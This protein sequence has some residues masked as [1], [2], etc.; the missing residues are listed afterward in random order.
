MLRVK[1]VARTEIG[2]KMY[3][4]FGRREGSPAA[5]MVIYQLPGANALDV[6]E[7]IQDADEGVVARPSRRGSS[8]RSSTTTRCS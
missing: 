7:K 4:S 1:D 5:V 3:T 8:T 6:A 2:A